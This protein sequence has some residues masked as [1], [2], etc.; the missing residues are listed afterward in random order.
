MNTTIVELPD[1]MPVGEAEP[2][3]TSDVSLLVCANK[4]RPKAPHRRPPPR[5]HAIRTA[6]GIVDASTHL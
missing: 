4:D 3:Y 5:K 1:N 6:P 2:A